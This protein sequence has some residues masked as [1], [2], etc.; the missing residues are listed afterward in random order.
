MV[1]EARSTSLS[2]PRT[3]GY[4]PVGFDPVSEVFLFPA[5]A[6]VFPD[7]MPFIAASVALP[8]ARGGISHG[9]PAALRASFSSPR[10]RG[11]FRDY[12]RI[13]RARRLFP[14]H[15]G[16]FPLPSVSADCVEALP[17]ARGGIS[18]RAQMAEYQRFSSPRTRGYFRVERVAPPACSLFPA[19]AGVFPTTRRCCGT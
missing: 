5:H 10:T 9:I 2:S 6:G 19:H 7:P 12:S 4:F 11:Y 15:A 18:V 1:K 3:R 17:R 13:V 8:R 14:A 16:V